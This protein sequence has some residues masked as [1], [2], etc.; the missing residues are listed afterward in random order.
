LRRTDWVIRHLADHVSQGDRLPGSR[1]AVEDDRV[2][3][4]REA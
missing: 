1:E 4:H 2:T 3:I